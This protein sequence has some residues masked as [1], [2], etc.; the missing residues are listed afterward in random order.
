MDCYSGKYMKVAK[1]KARMRL[2]AGRDM[3]MMIVICG[4]RKKPTRDKETK[5]QTATTISFWF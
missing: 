5:L 4:D 1:Q 3:M 2:L